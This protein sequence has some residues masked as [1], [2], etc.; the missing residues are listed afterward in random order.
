MSIISLFITQVLLD[1][2]GFCKP[3]EHM[4]Y[5]LYYYFNY[6]YRLSS[7]FQLIQEFKHNYHC[8]TGKSLYNAIQCH[9]M[10]SHRGMNHQVST[11]QMVNGLDGVT[12]IPLNMAILVK[13]GKILIWIITTSSLQ[14]QKRPW[15]SL[16]TI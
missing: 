16:D 12:V 15:G 5:V 2:D 6:N 1:C 4:Q 9:L 3:T 10:G 14:L 8:F 11:D 13:T 7:N